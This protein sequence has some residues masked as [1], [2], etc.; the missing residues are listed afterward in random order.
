MSSGIILDWGSEVQVGSILVQTDPVHVDRQA[1]FGLGS[2][3]E[4]LQQFLRSRDIPPTPSIK[5]TC[6]L[7]EQGTRLFARNVKEVKK[8][9]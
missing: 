1:A 4:R 8:T 3:S 5:V 2:C 9:Q 6:D 7:F